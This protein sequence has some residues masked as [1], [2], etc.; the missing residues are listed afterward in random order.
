[1]HHLGSRAWQEGTQVPPL[2]REEGRGAAGAWRADGM[3]SGSSCPTDEGKRSHPSPILPPCQ[4]WPLQGS[5]QW[6]GGGQA[7]P[8]YLGFPNTDHDPGC[9]EDLDMD[10]ASRGQALQKC[11]L[12]PGPG[13]F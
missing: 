3:A 9:G 7:G 1:M 10:S 5:L 13:L 4:A 2:P 8:A 6:G 12:Q 11:Q